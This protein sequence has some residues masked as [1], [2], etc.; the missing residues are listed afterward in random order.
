MPLLVPSQ[1]WT[2]LNRI[3]FGASSSV[4]K[5][6]EARAAIRNMPKIAL[7][8]FMI[9]LLHSEYIMNDIVDFKKL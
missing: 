1:T 8:N 3:Y 6:G 2:F 7:Y 4:A 9:S 5:A